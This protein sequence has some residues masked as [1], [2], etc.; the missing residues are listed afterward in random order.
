MQSWAAILA[1]AAQ[2]VLAAALIS[3]SICTEFLP[4]IETRTSVLMLLA[5]AGATAV[6]AAMARAA[7]AANVFMV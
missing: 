1:S 7:K 5:L 6:A 2:T 3:F 4:A